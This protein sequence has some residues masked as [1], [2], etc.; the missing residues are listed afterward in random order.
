MN[1]AVRGRLEDLQLN[2]EDGKERGGQARGVAGR[3]VADKGGVKNAEKMVR[4][5][6]GA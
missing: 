4:K 2:N 1:A 3:Q 6:V 5:G